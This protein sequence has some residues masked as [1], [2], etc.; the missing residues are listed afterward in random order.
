MV[1]FSFEISTNV[2]LKAWIYKS[3]IRDKSHMLDWIGLCSV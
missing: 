1:I 2:H 3:T